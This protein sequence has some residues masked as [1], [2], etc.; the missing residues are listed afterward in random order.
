METELR[1]IKISLEQARE[2]YNDTNSTLRKLALQAYSEKEIN[3]P[4]SLK[5]ISDSLGVKE[6]NLQ[7]RLS[8]KDGQDTANLIKEIGN[9][10]TLHMKLALIAKYFNGSWKPEVNNIKYFL[11]KSY[12]DVPLCHFESDLDNDFY[13]G[14]HKRVTYPGVVYFKDAES[15]KKAFKILKDKLY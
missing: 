4:Q 8:C 6:I 9:D 14:T 13:V 7:M 1:T 10:L 15:V 5:E 2:W 12:Q 11:A 3:E